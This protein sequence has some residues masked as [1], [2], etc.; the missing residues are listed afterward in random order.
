MTAGTGDT[1][2]DVRKPTLL[3]TVPPA[4]LRNGEQMEGAAGDV[5]EESETDLEDVRT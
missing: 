2:Q 1:R 4:S 3:G 5:T